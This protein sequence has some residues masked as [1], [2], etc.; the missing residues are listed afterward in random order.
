M[1]SEHK[2]EMKA[3]RRNIALK[4]AYDGTAYHGFQRQ[5]PPVVAV[6]NVLE[7]KLA[8]IFGDTIEM[9]ASGRTDAGVHAYG[10]V[11]N[12]FTNGSIPIDKVPMAVNS[13]LPDDIVVKEAWEADFDFSARH[14]AKAKTY[15]YRI[16][17][18]TTPNPLT[19]RYAWY[20][21][22]PLNVELMQQ[23]LDM[24]KGEHDF[25]AFRAAGGAPMSPVRTIYEAKVEAKPGD[26]LEFT[27]YGNGFLYHMVR[28]IIGTVANVGLGRI[29]LERFAEI[30]ASLDRHQASATA[31]ACGLY[32]YSVEY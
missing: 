25:S 3:R 8:V 16:Q 22:R 14:S 15:I 28:N 24:L 19:A 30:F 11:V 32:L 1:K 27:I 21:R 10:Q 7:R 5:S 29:S 4:V 26:M 12:F 9:A 6:Q 31:P 2:E 23:A 13:L 20:E 17:Q 18:G